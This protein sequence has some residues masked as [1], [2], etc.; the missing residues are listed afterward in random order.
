MTLVFPNEAR[1]I[2]PGRPACAVFLKSNKCLRNKTVIDVSEFLLKTNKE[3]N[4]LLILDE[5]NKWHT[6]ISLSTC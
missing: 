1:L 6:S 4:C 2:I 5:I 3:M